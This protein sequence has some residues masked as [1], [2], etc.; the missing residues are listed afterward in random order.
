MASIG[1]TN[2]ISMSQEMLLAAISPPFFE[3]HGWM[4][5]WIL[6]N[7]ASPIANDNQLFAGMDEEVFRKVDFFNMNCFGG[8]FWRDFWA[9]YGMGPEDWE[10]QRS[11]WR[12]RACPKQP[13]FAVHRMCCLGD[14]CLSRSASNGTCCH[15]GGK[16]SLHHCLK[17]PD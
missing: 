6:K 4:K 9:G 5:A 14:I 17:G 13:H 15:R 8:P 7:T 1:G 10:D 12:N 2:W 11:L 3:G 16:H